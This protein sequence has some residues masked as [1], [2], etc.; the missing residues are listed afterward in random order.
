MNASERRL[1]SSL[2]V[3]SG[4]L[5]RAVRRRNTQEGSY[6]EY[7]AFPNGAD[8]CWKADISKQARARSAPPLPLPRHVMQERR[9][10]NCWRCGLKRSQ[11]VRKPVDLRTIGG[12][13]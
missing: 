9:S 6:A 7:P 10:D 1:P 8:Q 4:H 11:L 13:L 3:S 12:L 2:G 5:R